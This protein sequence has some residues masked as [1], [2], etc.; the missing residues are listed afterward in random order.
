MLH[1][2]N[3]EFNDIKD[4]LINFRNLESP[5]QYHDWILITKENLFDN[6]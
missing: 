1:A 2:V 3:K 5:T 4:D 6:I